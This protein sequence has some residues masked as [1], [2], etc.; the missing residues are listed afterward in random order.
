MSQYQPFRI[1]TKDLEVPQETLKHWQRVV[2]I[3]TEIF[4]VPAALVMKVDSPYIEVLVSSQTEGNPYRMGDKEHLAGLYCNHVITS[5]KKLLVPNALED[6]NWK[7]NPDIKLGMISYLGFPLNWPNGDVFGTICVLDNKKNSYGKLFEKMLKEFKLLVETHLEL[8]YQQKNVKTSEERLFQ[9][10][11]SATDAI[12][13]LDSELNYI[14]VNKADTE[15]LSREKRKEDIIGR[16]ITDLIPGIKE[17]KRYGE[18]LKVLETGKPYTDIDVVHHP[19]FGEMHIHVSAFRVGNGLGI[20]TT[21]FT[22]RKKA[23]EVAEFLHSLLRHDIT[24]KLA[25]IN[26]YLSLLERS[27][28][29]E[30]QKEFT[31]IARRGCDEGLNLISKINSLRKIDQ[32]MMEE[33]K[34]TDLVR[35]V[36]DVVEGQ[37]GRA[38]DSGMK[39]ELERSRKKI[40]VQGGV[41]L[42]ELF[43]NLIENSI[44][45]SRGTILRIKVEEQGNLVNVLLEDNGKGISDTTKEKIFRRGFKGTDSKGTGLGLFLAKAIIETYGGSI[46]VKDSELGGARFDVTLKRV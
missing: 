20:I 6:E 24:N 13:L 28:L 10:M 40:E 30:K 15:M 19:E 31:S 36:E 23:E 35:V 26:G 21:N 5:Q 42:K 2:N 18:Y 37:A 4:D 32:G 45:H 3:L 39:I 1:S 43:N 16:N 9:L 29:S 22:A 41:L 8:L 25:V 34:K 44:I 11:E 17:S 7:D 38:T 12:S 33:I 14:D 46:T 27:R